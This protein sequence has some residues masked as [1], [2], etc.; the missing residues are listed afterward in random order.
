MA[1]HGGFE[2]K[3]RYITLEEVL[4]LRGTDTKIY[5]ESDDTIYLKFNGDT[6]CRYNKETNRIEAFGGCV[7]HTHKIYILEQE[8][9]CF[10]TGLYKTRDGRIAFISCID[11]YHISGMVLGDDYMTRWDLEGTFCG[12]KDLDLVEY[13]GDR[14]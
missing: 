9:K 3:K 7:L 5:G 1:N 12:N 6:L 8:D 2:M 14:K 11:E 10:C 4:E 13:V